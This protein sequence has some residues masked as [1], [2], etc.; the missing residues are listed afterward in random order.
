MS[1]YNI[2]PQDV[3]KTA[4]KVFLR[5]DY[6][7]NATDANVLVQ[8][9][10]SNGEVLRN[11]NLYIPSDIYAQWTTDDSVITNYVATQ[12]NFSYT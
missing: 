1:F 3:I 11:E 2:A 12:L 6:V 10:T 8:F 7:F 9:M 5:I 4:V